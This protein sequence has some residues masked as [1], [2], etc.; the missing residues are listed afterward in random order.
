MLFPS[1]S[2]EEGVDSVDDVDSILIHH[3]RRCEWLD[4]VMRLRPVV[5]LMSN[6]FSQR[7]HRDR[8]MEL[9]K[10]RGCGD[11]EEEENEWE[12]HVYMY[13]CIHA[14]PE[15]VLPADGSG[16]GLFC[17]FRI[18]YGFSAILATRLR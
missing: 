9:V 13:T 3:C 2:S 5:G 1:L 17:D 16:W 15:N 10:R 18:T 6:Y 11:E 14:S 8:D 4:S 12:E 7:K